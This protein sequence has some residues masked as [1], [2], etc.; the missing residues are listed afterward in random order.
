MDAY[1][2]SD[3]NALSIFNNPD[4]RGPVQD[5]SKLI[6]PKLYNK[7]CKLANDPKLKLGDVCKKPQEMWT[8][9]TQVRFLIEAIKS[10]IL[11]PFNLLRGP[12]FLLASIAMNEV[13][14]GLK[15]AEGVIVNETHLYRLYELES[16]IRVEFEWEKVE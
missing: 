4:N 5:I 11:T 8:T 9:F 7:I 15:V 10:Q 14:S 12:G 1:D 13:P 3:E 2:K 16:R 6:L